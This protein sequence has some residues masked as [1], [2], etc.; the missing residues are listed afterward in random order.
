MAIEVPQ[1]K[2]ISGRGKNGERK[3]S[4]LPSIGV[5][6]MGDHKD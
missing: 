1:I 6:R 2:E 3:E 5:E 4:V